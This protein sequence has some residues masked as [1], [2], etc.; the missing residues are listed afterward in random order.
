MNLETTSQLSHNQTV[1]ISASGAN[2]DWSVS[3]RQVTVAEHS[4]EF[5]K[6]LRK[7]AT[8]KPAIITAAII[9]T[10]FAIVAVVNLVGDARDRAHQAKIQR[11]SR[12]V[13]L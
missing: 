11:E 6:K 1:S 9:A 4:T 8:S 12:V 2:Y 5:A 13:V 3:G 7:V 10:V